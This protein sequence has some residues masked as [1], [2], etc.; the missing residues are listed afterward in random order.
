MQGMLGCGRLDHDGR[1]P[2]PGARRVTDINVPTWGCGVSGD[3]GHSSQTGDGRIRGPWKQRTTR[4]GSTAQ[5]CY[6]EQRP[7]GRKNCDG[8]TGVESWRGRRHRAQRR[9]D[10]GDYLGRRYEVPPPGH[11]RFLD[12]MPATKG[13]TMRRL[14]WPSTQVPTMRRVARWC[15][16]GPP[17]S[18]WHR[19]GLPGIRVRH[20]DREPG[21]LLATL[22]DERGWCPV[23][24]VRRIR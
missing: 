3:G 24:V 14:G 19:S 10:G 16:T 15:C 8:P 22:E 13:W 23:H 6:G 18:C 1:E 20:G 9:R 7:S 5:A 2:N 4:N 11:P 12:R 17:S 21:D